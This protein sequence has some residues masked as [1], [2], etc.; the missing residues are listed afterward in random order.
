[1]AAQTLQWEDY[2]PVSTLVVPEHPRPSAKFPFVDVHSHHR[3][4]TPEY[5]DQVVAEM[6]AMNMG[7][8]V[9]L[10]GGSGERLAQVVRAMKGRHPTRF[11]VFANPDFGGID[12]PGWGERAAARLERD[13]RVHGAQGL[14]IF[15]SLGLSVRDGAGRRVPTNDPRLDPLWAKAGELGVPVLI[16]TADPAPFW[17]PHDASNERWYEL[18]QI[19][20]RKQPPE[21]SW[22]RL[23]GEQHDVFRKHPGTRFIAAHLDWMGNDLGRLGRLLDELPNVYTEIGAVLAELGRQP[24]FARAFLTRYQDRVLFGKD[25]WAPDEYP[26]YFRTLE[27]ADDYFD[28][29]RK[30]HAFWKLYG[31]DLPDEVLRKLYY[32]NALRLIPGLDPAVFQ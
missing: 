20:G 9:N 21:P 31:L 8:L 30:R 23:M 13:V 7:V 10:S 17:Q 19:P 12:E 14:K 4:L 22:E 24:R 15:K 29:Y 2:E 6:D 28:Y 16:H 3:T 25:S 32:E 11:V 26:Y 27:T 1:A 5:V 18:K